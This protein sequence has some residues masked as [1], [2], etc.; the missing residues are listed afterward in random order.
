[1]F[2]RFILISITVLLANSFLAQPGKVPVEDKGGNKYHVHTVKKG[3]TAYGISRM[4]EVSINELYEH[5]PEAEKGLQIGQALY[6]PVKGEF[7]QKET[8]IEFDGEVI[9]HTVEEGETLYS[10]ARKYSVPAK[11]L[12]EANGQKTLAIGSQVKVPLLNAKKEDGVEPIVREV[13]NPIAS[14]GD[15]IILHKVKKNETLYSISKFY[16][17]TIEKIELANDGLKDGLKKGMKLRIPLKKIVQPI[18]QDTVNVIKDSSLT[19]VSTILDSSVIKEVYNVALM[20]PFFFEENKAAQLKCPPVGDCPIHSH[21]LRALGFHH[22]VL[23]AIDSLQKAGLNININVFDT[24]NNI[25][26]VNEILSKPEFQENNLIIGPFYAKQIKR[27]TEYAKANQVQLISPV[28]VSNKALFNNPYVTKLIASKPTQVEYLARYI[29]KNHH[30]DNV[31]L[32]RNKEDEKDEYYFRT[33]KKAYNEAILNYPNRLNDSVI[34]SFVNTR[35]GRL[36]SV[37]SKM[38]GDTNNIVVVPS[39]NVGHVSSFFTKLSSTSNANVY[40]TYSIKLFGLEDWMNFETIDEKYKNKYGLEMVTS[41]YVDYKDANV[42]EFIN[43]Y[44]IKFSTDPNKYSFIGF[45]ATFNSLKGLFLYGTQYPQHYSDL[46]NKGFFTDI[47]FQKVDEN[48]GYENK[49]VIIVEH[50]NYHVNKLHE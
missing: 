20:L 42:I 39:E 34:E 50:D 43:N 9:I 15:S 32:V 6:F 26:V 29:A 19:E 40:R 46:K 44:R 49:S 5:N 48:S 7:I 31:I 28:P 30:D 10:I 33:F 13:E 8:P 24:K 37:E 14:P 35:G 27:V 12:I 11:D 17:V 21:T 38:R 47:D 1:M 16:N 22:G 23:M 3:Q 18:V 36:T 2:L 45:D 25:D 41:G 4:Y